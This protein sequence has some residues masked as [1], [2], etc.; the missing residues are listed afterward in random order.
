LRKMAGGV[1][2]GQ[3]VGVALLYPCSRCHGWD[4]SASVWRLPALG[5]AE[6]SR[7]HEHRDGGGRMCAH[8]KAGVPASSVVSSGSASCA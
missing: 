1:R 7:A 2:C 6:R 8:S 3:E 5:A 4:G